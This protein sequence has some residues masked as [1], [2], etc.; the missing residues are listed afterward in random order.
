VVTLQDIHLPAQARAAYKLLLAENDLTAAQIGTKLGVSPNAIYRSLETL[1]KFG[2]V[3]EQDTYPA[4]FKA[5]APGES[6]ER[7][8]L[9]SREG[10]LSTFSKGEQDKAED[11]RINFIKDHRTILDRYMTDAKKARKEIN[12]II[13]GIELP[14]DVYLENLKSVRRGIRLRIIVQRYDET[15]KKY[16]QNLLDDGIDVRYSPVA[17][18]RFIAID[19][20]IIHQLF[21]D[22]KERLSGFGINIT[23]A[24]F[25]QMLSEVFDQKWNEAQEISG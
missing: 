16:V 6:V 23:Y 11:V 9:L 13:S 5:V 12:A 17:D 4:M 19:R 2:C 18:V 24:P 1:R 8:L 20:K 25:A 22:Q 14:E 3:V 10:F 21:Y 15:N 7:F